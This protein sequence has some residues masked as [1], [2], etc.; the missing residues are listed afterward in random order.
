MYFSSF[1]ENICRLD[2]DCIGVGISESDRIAYNRTDEKVNDLITRTVLTYE[3][4][5]DETLSYIPMFEIAFFGEPDSYI[6]P[7]V[8]YNGNAWGDGEEPKGMENS[9]QPWVFPS[10]RTGV[11]GCSI[12]E[13]GGVCRAVFAANDKSSANSSA[14]VFCVGGRTVQRIYFSHIEYPTAATKKSYP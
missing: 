14:S 13:S 3:N 2:G 8:N 7:C 10:D 11:P 5:S 12:T 6:V 9:G 1:K 4:A